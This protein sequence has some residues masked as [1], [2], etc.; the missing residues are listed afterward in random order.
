[1]A[2]A[3]AVG[4]GELPA[5]RRWGSQLAGQPQLAEVGDHA[6]SWLLVADAFAGHADAVLSQQRALPRRVGAG[7]PATVVLTGPG[8]RVRRDDPRLARRPRGPGDLARDHRPGRQ[9]G[10]TPPR[11]RRRLRRHGPAPPRGRTRGPGAHRARA[12]AGVEVGLLGLAALVHGAPGG[13]SGPRRTPGRPGADRRR[14][15]RGR[16]QPGRLRPGRPGG[17]TA[18]R[19]SA[20]TARHRVGVRGGRL[21]LPVGAHAPARRGRARRDRRVRTGRPRTRAHGRSRAA[22]TGAPEQHVAPCRA[23]G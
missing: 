21:P 19:R 5:A 9:Q 8:R 15:D 10:R 14:P 3:T 7:R 22:A 4:T 11:P 16:R 1:M 17:G 12:G 13:G 6:T 2:A 20:A 23:F 18:R